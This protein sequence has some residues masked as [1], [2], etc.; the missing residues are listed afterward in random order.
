MNMNDVEANG[1]VGTWHFGEID[2]LTTAGTCGCAC[3][4]V[5]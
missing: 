1:V 4:R 2:Y 5:C 3:T